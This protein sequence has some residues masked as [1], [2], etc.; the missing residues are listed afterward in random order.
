MADTTT[1]QVTYWPNYVACNRCCLRTTITVDGVCGTCLTFEHIADLEAQLAARDQ[2]IA[3]LREAVEAVQWG[4]E[5]YCDDLDRPESGVLYRHCPDCGNPEDDGHAECCIVGIALA[6][7]PAVEPKREYAIQGVVG[8][9][10]L[11][12]IAIKPEAEAR[13]WVS[14]FPHAY[15]LLSRISAG[16]WEPLSEPTK[17]GK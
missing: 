4:D 17:E 14:R 2:Q 8:D 15:R 5:R 9:R 3:R 7:T 11:D 1:Q 6:D 12:S 16:E 13:D 10:L